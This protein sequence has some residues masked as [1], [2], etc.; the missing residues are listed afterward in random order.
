MEESV[1]I[2]WA[3]IRRYLQC[4]PRLERRSEDA[5]KVAGLKEDFRIMDLNELVLHAMEGAD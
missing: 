3:L 5:R 4:V 1:L 2:P